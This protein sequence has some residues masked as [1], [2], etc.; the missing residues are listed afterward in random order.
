[1]RDAIHRDRG[2]R[3]DRLFES[4]TFRDPFGYIVTPNVDHVVRNWRDGGQLIEIYDDADL[5]LCDS[6]IVGLIGKLCGVKLPVVT[7][8]D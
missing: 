3:R 6:R 4:R 5:S 8:S 7:G 2:T 1:M